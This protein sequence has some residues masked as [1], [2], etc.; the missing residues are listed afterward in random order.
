VIAAG[1]QGHAQVGRVML[2]AVANS[3][4]RTLGGGAAV[5][6]HTGHALRLVERAAVCVKAQEPLLLVRLRLVTCERN[7]NAT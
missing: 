2:P 4:G 7:A 6:A 5:Y 1:T 3:A